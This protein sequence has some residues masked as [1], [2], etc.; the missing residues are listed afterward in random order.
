MAQAGI[1]SLV[2]TAMRRWTPERT[3]I[4]LGIVL[5]SLLPDTDN[6]AVAVAT[7]LKLPTEG[8]HRTFTHSLFTAL[9]VALVFMSLRSHPAGTLAQPGAGFG[10]RHPAA[11]PARLAHLV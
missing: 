1:H 5:G 11:H 7:V 6:L 8:L 4:L 2:G 10:D 3:W 9:A